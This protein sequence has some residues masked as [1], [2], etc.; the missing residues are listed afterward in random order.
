MAGEV[1]LEDLRVHLLL[2]TEDLEEPGLEAQPA[3]RV[4]LVEHRTEG[5]VEELAPV[6]V[7]EEILELPVGQL[8]EIG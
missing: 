8:P 5:D 4:L 6:V 2:V 1:A 7:V 3:L